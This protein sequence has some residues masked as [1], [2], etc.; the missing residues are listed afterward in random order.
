MLKCQGVTKSTEPRESQ[1]LDAMVLSSY[2]MCIAMKH[3][4]KC[5]LSSS[6]QAKQNRWLSDT[7][8]TFSHL[9]H[10]SI[11]LHRSQEVVLHIIFRERAD[12]SIN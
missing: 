1:A 8:Q 4:V 2:S 5:I 6:P 3:T 10:D 12:N 9:S 11:R 7:T